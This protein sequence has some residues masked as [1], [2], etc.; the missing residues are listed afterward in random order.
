MRVLI[1]KTSSL[2]DLIHT[3]P[4]ITDAVDAVPDIKFHW[5]VEKGFSEVPAWHPAVSRVI[6]IDWRRWRG[7]LLK[8]WKKGQLQ[9]FKRDLQADHYDLVIDAQ[10]LIKSAIPAWMA[11]GN[12]AGFDWDSAR[13]PLASFFYKNYYEVDRQQHAIT[14]VRQLFAAALDYSVPESAADYGISIDADKSITERPYLIFLHATTWSSKHWPESYW[15]QLCQLAVKA[16]FVVFLPWGSAEDRLRAERIM[17]RAGV[18]ELLPKLNLTQLAGRLQN[19]A[20]VVGVDS[21]LAHITAALGTPAV[22]L[23]G[24]TQVGL[25]G[26]IGSAQK[27]MAAK[28][29]CA[30][31]MSRDCKIALPRE[32][33]PPCFGSLPATSV[34]NQ[35]RQQMRGNNR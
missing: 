34:W 28:F 33:D 27:N 30:P 17:A 16:G 15:G 21:G 20:G 14:R 25:T 13:E 32:P 4:A 19:A 26:A 31:C 2:G 29:S 22:T 18:G 6:S 11:N 9:Q 24:S 12:T 3:F 1:I 8:Y 5:L 35:L 7:Q 10:G 23:Y